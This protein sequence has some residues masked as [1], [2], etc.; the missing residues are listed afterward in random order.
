M[1]I[2]VETNY[3]KGDKLDKSTTVMHKR[4]KYLPGFVQNFTHYKQQDYGFYYG[5]TTLTNVYRVSKYITPAID[6][7]DEA[8][9]LHD[10]GYDNFQANA[11]NGSTHLGTI[12]ADLGLVRRSKI[13]R[14]LGI[15]GVDPFNG[16]KISVNEWAAADNAILYFEGLVWDKIE[17]AASF[18]RSNYPSITKP[19]MKWYGNDIEAN[20]QYN[21]TKFRDMYYTFNTATDHYEPTKGMWSE[22]GS[23]PL[24]K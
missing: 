6:A 21:Y 12:E 9:R 17:S 16:Q 24:V 15:G 13:V 2:A 18:M 10:K 1:G 19:N 8:A 22:D 14:D 11:E 5:G 4:D 3:Y 7:V 23:T 20:Q